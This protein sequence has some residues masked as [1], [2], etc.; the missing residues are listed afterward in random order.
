MNLQTNT[1]IDSQQK[2]IDKMNEKS[3]ASKKMSTIFE[4]LCTFY[5]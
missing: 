2:V 5:W 1:I 4:E 3:E